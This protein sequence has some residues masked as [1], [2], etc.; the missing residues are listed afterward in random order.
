MGLFAGAGRGVGDSRRH[1][2][3]PS[4]LSRRRTSHRH[5]AEPGDAPFARRRARESGIEVDLRTGN[6]QDLPFPGAHFDTVVA[7][8]AL[9]TIPD[10]RQAVTE[11]ARVL[12]PGGRLLLLEHVRS[13]ILP[14]HVLQGILN[15]LSVLLENDHLLREP[16]RHVEDA[17]LVVESL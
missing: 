3:A 16:L 15:P 8:L 1:R 6:A 7:T 5:R 9:C 10:D 13:P 12:R 11:A 4:L 2:P 14:V 17:G